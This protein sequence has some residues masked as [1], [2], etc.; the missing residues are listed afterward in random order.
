MAEFKILVPLEIPVDETVIVIVVHVESGMAVTKDLPIF[1]I[2]TSKTSYVLG[3][4]VG[5]T[6]SHKL[7]PGNEVKSGQVLGI[8]FNED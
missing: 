7:S 4:E 6:L 8:V 2:E 5:G 1:E 3:A